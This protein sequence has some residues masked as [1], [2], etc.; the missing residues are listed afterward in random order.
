MTPT[1][2][3]KGDVIN[4]IGEP[5]KRLSLI[6]S[7]EV[8]AFLSGRSFK[9][10]KTD[11]I[12]LCDLATGRYSHTYTAS[13]DVTAYHYPC[14]GFASLDALLNGNADI[15]YL[16]VSSMCRWMSGHMQYWAKLRREAG[17]AF[18]LAE[19]LYP[20]YER[21]CRQYALTPKKLPALA[22]VKPFPEDKSVENWFYDYYVGIRNLEPAAHKGFFFGKPGI[23]SGFLRKCAVDFTAISRACELYT[24]YLKEISGLFAGG[25]GHDLFTLIAELHISTVAICGSDDSAEA[26]AQPL[27]SLIHGLP[28]VDAAGFQSRLRSYNEQLSAKRASGVTECVAVP[29]G[30]NQELAE[31]METILRYGECEDGTREQFVRLVREFT[32]L[33]AADRAGDEASSIRRELTTLFYE[34]Y[35]A[36]LKKSIA[37]GSAPTVVKMFLNFGYVDPALA[38]YEN[39][40]YLYSIADSMKGDPENSIYTVSEW[41]AAIYDGRIE[42]SLSEFDMDYPAYVREM[43]TSQQ[44]DAAE[45]TRL[46]ADRDEKLRYELDS[47]FPV[48]NRVTF[49][50]PS[51]FC[52][53]FASHNMQRRIETLQVTPARIKEILDEIRS[54]DFSAYYRQTAYTD[55]KYG[56]KDETINVEVLPN[57][58]LMPTV[59]IRGSM[60]QDIEGRKRATPARMFLPMF[61]DADLKGQLIKLTGEFRWEICRRIQG[62]RWN[63]VTDPSLTSLYCDYLQ[64]Y[65]N[66]RGLSM[67]TMMEIRNELSSARNNFKTVF[68][69]NYALWLLNESRGSS[70]LNKTAQSIM[71]TFCPFPASIRDSLINNPRYSDVLTKYNNKQALRVKRLTNLAQQVGQRGKGVPKEIRDEIEFSKR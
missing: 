57:I 42:P 62:A 6:A 34:A 40:E 64:F 12:G 47:A 46:L 23:S 45:E 37:H 13:T 30:G 71:A 44:I 41:M 59:G 38:G 11:M 39:A 9:L 61:L 60:W 26:L 50:K 8:E 43:K 2:Y 28:G 65:M 53:V 3:K 49:G 55:P 25:D 66:N 36:A 17:R 29:I 22:G 67:E 20:E 56:I 63:D 10:E 48:L 52:P 68:V 21:I 24:G 32:D 54:V 19:S 27:I 16:T 69:S 31:S 18:E 51:K 1:E 35:K 70:R 5:V 14:E 4:S 15:A 33:S 7:G 58:V